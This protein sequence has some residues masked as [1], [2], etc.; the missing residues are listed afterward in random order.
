MTM[1]IGRMEDMSLQTWLKHVLLPLKWI[2]KVVNVP[3][4]FN[5]D[6]NRFEAQIVWLPNFLDEGRGW[7]I[8]D[9]Q[10]F[11]SCVVNNIP[12]AE[13]TSRITVYNENGSVINP[14]NYVVNYSEGSIL[15]INGTSTPEGVPTSIDF[16]QQYVSVI[17]GWPGTNPPSTPIV[18]VETGPYQKDPLQLGPGRITRRNM[19]V[20]IFATSS[21]ERDDLTEF[22]LD[23]FN[24]RH[25]PIFDFRQGEPLNYDGT[26]N[27]NWT[28]KL[29][30]LHTNDD[31]LFYF[32]KVR[33]DTI[34]S[35]SEWGD[36]NRWRSK[37]TF[38]SEA[39]RQG[40]E[41]NIL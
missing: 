29:L 32:R 21:A 5:G 6:K 39:Y 34:S 11:N 24:N 25:L 27:Q 3:L 23:A 26:F 33:A 31:A 28:G 13:Q 18:A 38:V 35:R 20:H 16:Y 12:S 40:L 15:A 9:P 14:S 2:E 37:V 19:T 17:D 41:F 22:L 4:E 7:T 10:G 8:F 36:L 30:K 1:S